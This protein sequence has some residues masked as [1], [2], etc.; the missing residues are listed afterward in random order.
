MRSAKRHGHNALLGAALAL[1]AGPSW[2]QTRPLLTEEAGTAPAGTI[3]LEVGVDAITNEPS[4]LSGELRDRAEGPTPNLVYSP[5]D[6]V[7]LDL[8]WVVRTFAIDDPEF[9][10][11]SDFG[12]VALR[13]K[14]RFVEEG[15]R[16]P[17]IGAR[18]SVTL[19][20]TSFT[21]EALG[22]NTIRMS[23]Q[24]LLSKSF[25][26]GF[27]IHLNAGL[28]IHDQIADL[29]S[30]SDFLQYGAALTRRF[31]RFEAVLEAAGLLGDGQAGT[32]EHGEARAGVRLG[33]GRVRW[34][35]ALRRGF[36]P[37]DGEWGFTAGLT[38]E[39]RQGS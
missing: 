4:F 11:V 24:M 9:G 12:D 29:P 15:S 13:A 1:S 10:T 22:P 16:R 38:W 6:N 27:G 37:A 23:A 28:A 35:L 8:G 2:A 3:R 14:V 33:E 34:D 26:S 5:S 31:A 20:Q 7:E 30:Q 32:D 21:P 36:M 17:A 18:F 39:I 25:G 19:P